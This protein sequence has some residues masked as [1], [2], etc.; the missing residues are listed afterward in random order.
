MRDA[1]SVIGQWIGAMV[2][3][4]VLIGVV[5]TDWAVAQPVLLNAS[6]IMI[7]VD[8]ASNTGSTL[9]YFR[10]DPQTS[11]TDKIRVGLS[12]GDF[13]SQTTGRG[14]G[15]KALFAALTDSA[16]KPLH[17][18]EFTEPG[19]NFSVRVDVTNLWEAGE[20]EAEL[21]NNGAKIGVLRAVKYRVPFSVKLDGVPP[22]RPEVVLQWRKASAHGQLLLKNEDTMT[23]QLDWSLVLDGKEA[24]KGQGVLLPPQGM[25][26]IP[27]T[28][29]DEW[30]PWASSIYRDDILDG[31]LQLS[32]RPRGYTNDSTLPSKTIPLRARLRYWSA[33][34]QL[35]TGLGLVF[36][37]LLLGGLCSMV[38]RYWLP[39]Q[40][41]IL[42]VKDQLAKLT[43][44]TQSLTGTLDSSV[45]VLVRVQRDR[46]LALLRSRWKFSPDM[47]TTLA[48]C[49]K[50][51]ATLNQQLDLLEKID[52][53]Q[54]SVE[55]LRI[56]GA[57]PTLIDNI[58]VSL[59]G[60][61]P[62]PCG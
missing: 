7:I 10:S 49:N 61:V 15:A 42:D 62:A 13:I 34:S 37:P 25:T 8:P 26:M 14:L 50:G 56:N 48:Q 46:L 12:A 59:T 47:P 18:A 43:Q 3:G 6:P 17:E 19:K 32:F 2:L 36:V 27:V 39:N 29:A 45:R 54:A 55:T 4:L 16:G 5:K 51:I 38:L 22:E 44:R 20:S 28:L 33:T 1:L 52:Q 31:Q 30:F 11:P 58:E 57:A 41:A 23:Y 53:T 40:M 24:S 60:R 21:L 9:L 35:V